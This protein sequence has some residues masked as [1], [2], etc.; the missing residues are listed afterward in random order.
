MNNFYKVFI[1]TGLRFWGMTLAFVTGLF[2]SQTEELRLCKVCEI[3]KPLNEFYLHKGHK[4]PGRV[5]KSCCIKKNKLSRE[6][7][8]ERYP[9]YNSEANKKYR[10]HKTE[11][12][13]IYNQRR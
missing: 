3:E 11:L 10:K 7:F 6:I 4:N 13:K 2:V 8:L 1:D 12:Q 5:C 9:F